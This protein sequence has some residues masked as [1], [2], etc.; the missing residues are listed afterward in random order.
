MNKRLFIALLSGGFLASLAHAQD[1]GKGAHL[2]AP[3]AAKSRA[4]VESLSGPSVDF[5]RREIAELISGAHPTADWMATRIGAPMYLR[6]PDGDAPGD[7]GADGLFGHVRWREQGGVQGLLQQ[8]DAVGERLKSRLF[9]DE[10]SRK[11]EIEVD[12]SPE[13]KYRLEFD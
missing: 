12:G 6:D 9:G 3:A 1:A 7:V 5:D 11:L 10:L 8:Y 13:I 2:D 4:P